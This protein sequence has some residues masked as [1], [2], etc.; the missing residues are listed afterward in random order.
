[1]ACGLSACKNLAFCE[2]INLMAALAGARYPLRD[3]SITCVPFTLQ[4]V[5]YKC[6]SYHA[7]ILLLS[8]RSDIDVLWFMND[9]ITIISHVK[10]DSK[11]IFKSINDFPRI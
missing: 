11:R 8:T 5:P 1:M 4:P 10:S 3:A 7:P 2:D 6:N 9:L